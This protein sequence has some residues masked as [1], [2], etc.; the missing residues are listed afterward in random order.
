MDALVKQMGRLYGVSFSDL[1]QSES[2]QRKDADTT[3]RTEFVNNDK[4]LK[5]ELEN[6]IT[7][8]VNLSASALT[9]AYKD[10]D[11]KVKS[12]CTA[13]SNGNLAT[14]R[15][16]IATAKSDIISMYTSADSDLKTA[17]DTLSNSI[18]NQIEDAVLSSNPIKAYNG[19]SIEFTN[20]LLVQW[21]VTDNIWPERGSTVN[22]PTEFGTACNAVLLTTYCEAG[23]HADV[24]AQLNSFDKTKFTWFAQANGDVV[25]VKITWIAIGH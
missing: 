23:A 5:T 12:E 19:Y 22:F 9:T 24:W 17:L 8:K 4:T 6:L 3:L 18:P 14:A 2:Q 7:S 20:G 13:L 16:E 21:G 15:Q 11:N 10:A 25:N 1:I